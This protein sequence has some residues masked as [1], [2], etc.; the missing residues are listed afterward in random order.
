MVLFASPLRCPIKLN[1][2]TQSGSVAEPA[3]VGSGR[4]GSCAKLPISVFCASAALMRPS[5]APR[6]SRS[7]SMASSMRL[8]SLAASELSLRGTN[9][10]RLSTE[11]IS[12]LP[13]ALP[14]TRIELART[15]AGRS[16]KT[17]VCSPASNLTV[18]NRVTSAPAGNT[19]TALTRE[20]PKTSAAS[21]AAACSSKATNNATCPARIGMASLPLRRAQAYANDP[22]DLASR[23]G[24]NMTEM[25]QTDGM[26]PGA[27]AAGRR[28]AA[29]CSKHQWVHPDHLRQGANLIQDLLA[30]RFVD[31]HHAD[32]I[33]A[34]LVAPQVQ[35][36]DVKPGLPH[37]HAEIADEARLVEIA[38]EQHAWCQLELHVD[39]A[40]LNDARSAVGKHRAGDGAVVLVGSDRQPNV[41]FEGALLTA[42]YF[43]KAHA[44]LFG[45][46]AG[47]H[48]I[49]VR[50]QWPQHTCQRRGRQ[51]P[52]VERGDFT[53]IFEPNALDAGLRELARK[54]AKLFGE[55]HPGPQ[56]RRL[57]GADAG[58]VDRIGNRPL[59]QVVRHLFGD[60]QGDIFL[61]LAGGGAQMRRADHI[62]QAEQRAGRGGLHLEHIKSGARYLPR[63][64]R[65]GQ[66]MLVDQAAARAIDD[67]HAPLGFAQLRGIEDVAGLVGER[68]V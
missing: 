68:R 34:R 67:A 53:G 6:S 28:G 1:S 42:R 3:P 37:Q 58:E 45:A 40:H 57:L 17:M 13:V 35:G 56:P 64:D 41:A 10:R 18:P 61:R 25:A 43:L 26:H 11:P 33:A 30:H 9:R 7:F 49:D 38:D 14:S 21:A 62:R 22:I 23:Q 16:A 47:R 24:A 5:R 31:R 39:V 2:C 44:T 27:S 19:I 8:R 63:F 12:S 52:G 55:F 29:R 59:E 15:R 4:N 60:L 66:S 65:L 46:A 51:R 48:H 36:G 32:G 54:Q 20:L 50:Q